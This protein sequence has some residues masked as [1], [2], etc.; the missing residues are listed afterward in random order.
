M[1]N[2]KNS[3]KKLA[4]EWLFKAQEDE[5]SARDILED[6]QG[7]PSTVCFLSQQMAEKILKGYLVFK[8]KKFPKIHDLDRLVKLC[9]EFDKSFKRI[10][11]Q[12]R[13]LS[14]FYITTRYPGDYPEFNWREAEEA[15]RSA[16]KI[17][18]FVLERLEFL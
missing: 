17:K 2:Q 7:A 10:K 16:I 11:S 9:Q 5:L 1:K 18:N 6:K 13:Y 3:L 12:A 14:N 8:G 15:F 4:G